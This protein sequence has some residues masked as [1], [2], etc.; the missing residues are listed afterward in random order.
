MGSF[1]NFKNYF[2]SMQEWVRYG[3]DI[4]WDDYTILKNHGDYIEIMFPFS[5]PKGH[6]TYD[7]YFDDSGKLKKVSGHKG[8]AGFEDTKTYNY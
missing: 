5:A 2:P 8:N 4:A 7:M 6:D 1:N 3:C